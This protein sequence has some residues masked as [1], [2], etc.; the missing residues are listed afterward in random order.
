MRTTLFFSLFIGLFSFLSAAPHLHSLPQDITLKSGRVLKDVEVVRWERDRVVVKY[1]GGQVEP[2]PFSLIT[3]VSQE[4]LQFLANQGKSA[5]KNPPK[6][7]ANSPQNG[8]QEQLMAAIASK[9]RERADHYYHEGKKD[10]FASSLV[11]NLVI[12]LE[13]P[14]G[15]A[16]WGD[17]YG[18]NGTAHFDVYDSYWGGSFSSGHGRFSCEMKQLSGGALEITSFTPKN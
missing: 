9:A 10:R 15:V 13:E 18:V 3:N 12:D 5:P 1:F 2:V 6:A 11:F 4:D 7:A 17:R 14:Q 16:G 8:S